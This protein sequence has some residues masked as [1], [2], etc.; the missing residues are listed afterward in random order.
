MTF[1]PSFRHLL[2]GCSLI[3]V[4]SAGLILGQQRYG[5][6]KTVIHLVTLKWK[7]DATEAQRQKAIDGVKGMA[8]AIPG[9]KNVWVKTL[10]VQSPSQEKP[11]DAAF[12][13][14]FESEAA[15]KAYADHPK[16]KEWEG[17]YLPVREESRSHQVTN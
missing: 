11:Y 3:A 8:G 7:A 10:R 16:H 14:E 9:I 2:V 12:A 15:A 17:I 5:T 1:S 13:I 6:P 4:F